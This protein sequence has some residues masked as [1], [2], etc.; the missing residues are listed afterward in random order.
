M[1]PKLFGSPQLFYL[2][3]LFLLLLNGCAPTEP[4]GPPATPSPTPTLPPLAQAV[5]VEETAIVV[6]IPIDP[7]SFNAYLNDTGYEMLAGEL[8]YG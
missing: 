1:M 5:D 8:V 6:A 3:L 4:A 2:W 7:P